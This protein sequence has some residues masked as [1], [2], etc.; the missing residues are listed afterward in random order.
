MFPSC[1]IV[2]YRKHIRDL[3][4]KLGLQRDQQQPRGGVDASL[5]PLGGD[6][7]FLG[8]TIDW[9]AGG[10]NGGGRMERDANYNYDAVMFRLDE[11]RRRWERNC[12]NVP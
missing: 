8:D 10:G 4:A 6:S 2:G 12:R 7:G 1:Q 9:S 3:E 5:F 11:E